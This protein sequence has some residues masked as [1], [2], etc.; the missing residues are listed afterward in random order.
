ME[1]NTSE[2]LHHLGHEADVEDRPGQLNMPKVPRALPHAARTGSTARVAI[3]STLSWVH[4]AANSG[5]AILRGDSMTYATISDGH[6]PLG[7]E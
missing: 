6:A 5:T 4:E 7:K 2:Q 3:H 1:A